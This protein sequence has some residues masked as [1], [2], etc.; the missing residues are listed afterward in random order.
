[1]PDQ[2]PEPHQ[3]DHVDLIVSK[4]GAAAGQRR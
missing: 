2:L 3:A 4:V 1:V